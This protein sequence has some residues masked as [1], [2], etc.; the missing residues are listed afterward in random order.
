MGG[1]ASSAYRVWRFRDGKPGHDNQTAGLIAALRERTAVEVFEP[2]C[3]TRFSAILYWASGRFPPGRDLPAPDLL[4]GAGHGTHLS[5]LAARRAR[6]GHSIVLM[7]PS[8]PCDWF[9]LCV[10]PEHDT[11]PAGENIFTTWGVINRIRPAA[12][13]DRSLGVF[14][15]GGPSRHHGWQNEHMMEQVKS[16]V[17]HFPNHRWELTTSRRTPA[18]WLGYLREHLEPGLLR[19][20]TLN[21]WHDLGPDWL[22]QRLALADSVWV[23]EDS[24][25]MIYEA[26]TAGAAVGLLDVPVK[27]KSRVARGI[28]TLLQSERVVRYADWLAGKKLKAMR[29]PLDEAGRCAEEIL[30]RWPRAV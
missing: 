2:P 15:I 7:K 12:V 23:S 14:L 22:P 19:R 29:A 16:V 18:G 5:L 28:Q 6:G 24:V 9:D 3:P 30:K 26:L 20:L 27:G 25:S 10:V 8:L 13:K 21:D 4:L 1:A 17:S 11:V